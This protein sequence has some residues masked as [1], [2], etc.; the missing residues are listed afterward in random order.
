MNGQY[1]EEEM[2]MGVEEHEMQGP[3]LVNILEQA[4]INAT[5]VNKLKDAGMH[6][7][8]AVAMATKKQLV[9]IKGISEVKAEK[10]LKAAREMVNVGFTTAADVLES[11]KD[12]ITL[13]TGSNAV[14]ELLKGG[15]ETGSITEMFGEFRTGKTQLCHQLCVTCQLPVDRGGG[16][17]KALYIDTEGT[18][19][20]Q[21]LQ[22]IAERYGLDG[23]S[24]LDN[25][26]FARAYNSEHQMQLLIQ[27]SAMMAES[28]FA[29]VI[30]DSATALFRTDYSGR[31]ELAA[32]QQELAKFLRALTRMADE[33]GVAVVITNQ[34]TANPDSGMFAK[35][36]LQPIGGNIMAHASCTRLRLKKGRGENRVMKVV[37][38][39]ILPESEAIYSITEQGIQDELN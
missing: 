25:V 3:R 33:F 28:R 26:A 10:M 1:Q 32:R 4:G 20:P 38:S 6:T 18:F 12:L 15:I 30:V 39:P 36:P 21:R 34:M 13:S 29:L 27:A 8:D 5:D 24:V 14:D 7:V 11:R 19:R 2:D 9:G 16:E 35:D 23:D 17:G 37:D 31:G 22:A